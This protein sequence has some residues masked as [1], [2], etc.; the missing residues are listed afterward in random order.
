MELSKLAV[1]D[2]PQIIDEVLKNEINYHRKNYKS[3]SDAFKG[4]GLKTF[5]ESRFQKKNSD[6]LKPPVYKVKVWYS[7][8]A[9]EESTLK[10]LYYNNDKLSVLTGDNYLFLVMEHNG[11]RVFD[12]ASLFDSAD[13]ARRALM[14]KDENYKQKICE[15]Y[16]LSYGERNKI[17]GKPQENPDKLLFTLQQ[18][19]LVYF[20]EN[21]DDPV[22]N[23]N[24]ADIEKWLLNS[25]NRKSFS[26][27]V[28]KVVMFT[29]KECK[30][31]LHNYANAIS[32]PKDLTENQK[33]DL[34][35]K[36]TE[37]KGIPKAE[38]NFVEYG[39]Y[40]DS[41]PYETGYIFIKSLTDKNF[42]TKPKKIQDTCIKIEI[43]W[44]G[45]ISIPKL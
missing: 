30:F 45:K 14:E 44:L 5:N 41:S 23:F 1:K 18:N 31:I 20:P 37:K 10:R 27:R 4:E 38:L 21:A 9:T 32:V 6:K 24:N 11:K 39:S 17:K 35:K 25:D 3:M 16:R 13:I 12:I 36:Y 28:Y 29:G 7:A 43:D 33:E 2:I 15:E 40:R 19:D 26:K 22:K 8:K 42:K 34:K